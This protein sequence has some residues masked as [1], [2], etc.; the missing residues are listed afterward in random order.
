MAQELPSPAIRTIH[1]RLTRGS[2]AE[3]ITIQ[4]EALPRRNGT[5]HDCSAESEPCC[6]A[7]FAEDE[8]D[9]AIQGECDKTF[10]SNRWLYTT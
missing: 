5:F 7:A 8:V 4:A 6:T 9:E 1:V 2:H 10:G 3:E